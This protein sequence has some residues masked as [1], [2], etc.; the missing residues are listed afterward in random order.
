MGNYASSSNEKKGLTEYV[1]QKKNYS[2]AS[3]CTSSWINRVDGDTEQTVLFKNLVKEKIDFFR[4]PLFSFF[5][6]NEGSEKLLEWKLNDELGE[7]DE[8]R[9]TN[10]KTSGN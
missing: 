9:G 2:A 3:N 5:L 10:R 6:I 8:K 4:F 7:R 1:S